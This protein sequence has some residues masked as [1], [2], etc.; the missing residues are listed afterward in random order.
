MCETIWGLRY[1]A[2][3]ERCPTRL[4]RN[5]TATQGHGG[6]PISYSMNGIMRKPVIGVSEQV[7]HKPGCIA[8]DDG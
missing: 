8:T 3:E 2:D 7:Q 6:T 4:H 1:H 5:Y